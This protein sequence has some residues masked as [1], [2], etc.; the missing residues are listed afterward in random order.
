MNWE[1][2]TSDKKECKWPLLYRVTFVKIQKFFLAMPTA[3]RRSRA[4]DRTSTTVVATLDPYLCHS[5][6][7]WKSQFLDRQKLLPE[8]N[9]IKPN[10]YKFSYLYLNKEKKK[11]EVRNGRNAAW[12][13]AANMRKQLSHHHQ[14]TKATSASTNRGWDGKSLVLDV[15][16]E[17]GHWESAVCPETT[18]QTVRWCVTK[19]H[20]TAKSL[21]STGNS[22]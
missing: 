4:R 8:L 17:E 5:G 9:K 16:H 18:D 19:P 1:K 3:G 11:A 2:I 22:I 10:N 12:Q 13:K 6:T 14:R 15:R 20:H 7:S 21:N